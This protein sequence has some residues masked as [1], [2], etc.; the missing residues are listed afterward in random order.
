MTPLAHQIA[1]QATVGVSQRRFKEPQIAPV[2]RQWPQGLLRHI[3]EAHCFETTAVLDLA[4]SLTLM[5][6][7]GERSVLTVDGHDLP[8]MGKKDEENFNTIAA[9]KTFLPAPVTWIEFQEQGLPR[10]G[11][12]LVDDLYH[13]PE[14]DDG[15]RQWIT[16]LRCDEDGCNLAFSF[17]KGGEPQQAVMHPLKP[18]DEAS[19]SGI[20]AVHLYLFATIVI[21]NLA[22][23]NTPRI[24]GR[25]THL[26]HRGLQKRLG[27]TYRLPGRYPLQA[28]H[29]VL[30]QV[31]VPCERGPED[32]EGTL[33]GTRALHFCRSYLRIRRG[34]LEVVNWH[35]RGN[36]ALGIRQTR[37]RVV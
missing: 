4:R 9:Q 8:A 11:F 21:S 37:Y 32:A 16:V 27:Q 30:L 5:G 6:D 31:R 3:C 13:D 33:T 15:E 23:I 18:A 19:M 1:K 2:R 7:P 20:R 26:P 17:P 24:V 25:T 14:G 36:P 28:W 29:E 22:I 34:Q 10:D 12:L 35:W